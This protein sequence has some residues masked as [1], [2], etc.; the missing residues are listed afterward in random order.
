MGQGSV[1]RFSRIRCRMDVLDL[2]SV[3]FSRTVAGQRVHECLYF[4]WQR[5]STF[6]GPNISA[7]RVAG[8]TASG[9]GAKHHWT[10]YW[11]VAAEC[12]RSFHLPAAADAGGGCSVGVREAW[13][14]HALHMGQHDADVEF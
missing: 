4:R 5:R 10:K 11:K 2:Y 14:G 7:D 13:L 1:W 8:T 3:L 12:R 9:C 6:S